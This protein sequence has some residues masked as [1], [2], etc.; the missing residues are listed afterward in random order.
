[1]YGNVI[2]QLIPRE[3]AYI[4]VLEMVADWLLLGT[5]GEDLHSHSLSL[6]IDNQG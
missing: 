6:F 3:D 5:S 4:G 1:M 2:A